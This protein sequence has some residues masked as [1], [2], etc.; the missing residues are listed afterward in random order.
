MSKKED[1]RFI[2]WV[3]YQKGDQTA[4]L[5]EKMFKNVRK[6]WNYWL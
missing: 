5:C 3:R 4:D 6:G 2:D 1:L